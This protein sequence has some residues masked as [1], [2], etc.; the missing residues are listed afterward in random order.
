[1]PDLQIRGLA[2]SIA[3]APPNFKPPFVASF[4]NSI[5]EGI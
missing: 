2:L 5:T 4:R 1:M 3:R